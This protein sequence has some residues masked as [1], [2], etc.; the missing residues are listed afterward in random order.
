MGT[1]F[2][3]NCASNQ[4]AGAL[5]AKVVTGFASGAKGGREATKVRQNKKLELFS[6]SALVEQPA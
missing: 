1:G 3:I 5:S 2:R 4:K 6:D